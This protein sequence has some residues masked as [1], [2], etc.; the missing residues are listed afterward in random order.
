M[1]TSTDNGATWGAPVQVNDDSTG[2]SQFFPALAV[3]QATGNLLRAIKRKMAR[4]Q[5][6][7]DYTKLRKDG[8][9]DRF[10]ARLEE[11]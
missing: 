3:D 10:L 11:A 5:R 4:K 8:Y 9:S 6:G 7:L 1:R 2:N